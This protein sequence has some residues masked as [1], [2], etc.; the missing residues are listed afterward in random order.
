MKNLLTLSGLMVFGMSLPTQGALTLTLNFDD[1]GTGGSW[2]SLKND[3]WDG[4]TSDA[5]KQ[6]AAQ[7]VIQAAA[8]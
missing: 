8:Q 6:A 4:S 7:S 2:S 1:F 5:T 3:A